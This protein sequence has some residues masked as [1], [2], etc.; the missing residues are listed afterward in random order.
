MAQLQRK[1]DASWLDRI[2]LSM[3]IDYQP[4]R[5][6]VKPLDQKHT[7]HVITQLKTITEAVWA[8][9]QKRWGSGEHNGTVKSLDQLAQLTVTDE[10]FSLL[11][12]IKQQQSF[13]ERSYNKLLLVASTIADIEAVINHQT[14]SPAV[15]AKHIAEATQLRIKLFSS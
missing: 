14:N 8:L 11:H 15:A 2:S 4:A 12:Q 5:W 13:S 9:Q 10:A 6:R 7:Q 3:Y 1:L